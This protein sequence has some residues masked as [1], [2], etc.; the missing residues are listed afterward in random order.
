[1]TPV[2]CQGG[3]Q[4]IA[5]MFQKF[6]LVDVSDFFFLLSRGEGG[7][8]ATGR[9]GVGVLLEIPGGGVEGAGRVPAGNSGGGGGLNIFFRGRNARQV[10]GPKKHINF[11]NINFSA[12][13][14]NTPFWA[15]RKK[16]KCASFP[17]KG[18]KKGTHINFFGAILGVSKGAPN[19]PFSATKSLVYCFLPALII[20]WN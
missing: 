12:P 2:K 20:V 9:E 17:G 1:M 3:N 16:F 11:F 4:K 6:S 19:R 10:R 14:Q 13:T 15:P 8:R 5:A 7:V 18:R